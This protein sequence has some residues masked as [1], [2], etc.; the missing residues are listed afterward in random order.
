[1]NSTILACPDGR[2]GEKAGLV[3]FRCS[4]E[5]SP[6]HYCPATSTTPKTIACPEGTFN[7]LAG[8][9]ESG[10]CIDCP[11]DS[12][13]LRGA[14]TP[15]ACSL[16]LSTTSTGKASVLDCVCKVGTYGN[17][18][19]G[20]V[21]TRCPPL[22]NNCSVPG[23]TLEDLPILPG[24]W[25]VS[26]DYAIL[27]RCSPSKLCI[28]TQN[29][30]A[31]RP[32]ETDDYLCAPGHVGPYCALCATDYFLS[33]EGSCTPCED[34]GGGGGSMGMIVVAVI[35]GILFFAVCGYCYRMRQRHS[36]AGSRPI[37]C[38][39]GLKD[40][41]DKDLTAIPDIDDTN[42]ALSTIVPGA[43]SGAPSATPSNTEGGGR[44]KRSVFRVLGKVASSSKYN[45]TKIKML[46]TLYQILSTIG[47]VFNIDY[48][49]TYVNLLRWLSIAN[50]DF[51]SFVPLA[52]TQLPSGFYAT[53]VLRTAVPALLV[54]ALY[55]FGKLRNA[56]RAGN[57]S[58]DDSIASACF[59]IAFVLLFLL[60]PG[61]TNTYVAGDRNG[62]AGLS[63][64]VN[65][66]LSL[67]SQQLSDR[68]SLIDSL[69]LVRRALTTFLCQKLDNGTPIL[70]A[71]FSIICDGPDYLVAR[72]YSLIMIGLFPVGTPC[73]YLYLLFKHRHTLHHLR[74]EEERG[75]AQHLLR[76]VRRQSF[77]ENAAG[78]ALASFMKNAAGEEA[79]S[80]AGGSLAERSAFPS[81]LIGDLT[82]HSVNIKE[83]EHE[84][85]VRVLPGYMVRIIGHYRMETYW[86]EVFECVRKVALIGLPIAFETGSILQHQFGLLVSFITFGCFLSYKPF[87]DPIDNQLEVLCQLAIFVAMLTGIVLRTNIDGFALQVASGVMHTC[88]LGPAIAIFIVGSPLYQVLT[89]R[90]SKYKDG[91]LFN[92]IERE[93]TRLTR[94]RGSQR[95]DVSTSFLSELSVDKERCSSASAGAA[96]AT[97][98]TAALPPSTPAERPPRDGT[99][100]AQGGDTQEI[101][102]T[103]D[104][105]TKRGRA[106]QLD[107]SRV[108]GRRASVPATPKRAGVDASLERS[109]PPSNPNSTSRPLNMLKREKTRLTMRRASNTMG[110]A[111]ANAEGSMVHLLVKG[112][113]TQGTVLKRAG[114]R[115]RIKKT[116]GSTSWVEVKDLIS[117]EQA[118]AQAEKAAK[119]AVSDLASYLQ[120][121]PHPVPTEQARAIKASLVEAH[122]EEAKARAAADEEQCSSASAGAAEASTTTAQPTELCSEARSPPPAAGSSTA[123]LPPSTPAERPPRDGTSTA[124]G[125]DTQEIESTY[126][127]TTKRGRAVQL[128]LSRVLGR[129]ASVPATPKRAGVDASLERSPPPSNPN[130]TRRMLRRQQ[131]AA[132]PVRV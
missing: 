3:D 23:M 30:T 81:A 48:P 14:E 55:L 125:G 56:R 117:A 70:K 119:P 130:S 21:C 58:P 19:H 74:R 72:L 83:K 89:E 118:R 61:C 79:T 88:A 51:L 92:V 132:G 25:R 73:L 77:M 75:E 66:S 29:A 105:T 106:V 22:G 98:T 123:A 110:D 50:V 52:C 121:R 59:S 20:G 120:P 26:R 41:L 69:F 104:S 42:N 49:D 39:C 64:L 15:I 129:R 127:S 99:S 62:W 13:C 10:A 43:S 33:Q 113:A 53:L 116:D 34:A 80:E 78:G 60:Y 96:E 67:P 27:H 44:S 11:K 7:P 97:T 54:T 126:D 37:C 100:T 47:G 4:G 86:F 90:Y 102:S 32:N 31:R 82:E 6:G 1:M 131:S 45:A 38:S 108:L 85:A 2:Y 128:D 112:V 24:W 35:L 46:V 91:R 5:C 114:G 71:D 18:S 16:G 40:L 65:S 8:Q 63:C 122:K 68:R 12:Y 9:G 84:E 94:Q 57:S 28:G 93:K 115:V 107:L 101:E 103:Y 95:R 17:G 87:I 109:P 111:T 76:Q 36:P 124:Q